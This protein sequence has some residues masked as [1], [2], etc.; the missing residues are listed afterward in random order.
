MAYSKAAPQS[1]LGRVISPAEPVK[2]GDKNVLKFTV[3]VDRLVTYQ[4]SQGKY[5][6]K[7]LYIECYY[8]PYGKNP[9]LDPVIAV[10]TRISTKDAKN[11]TLAGATY[12]YVD[13]WVS[14]REEYFETKNGKLIKKLNHCDVQ[15]TD[16]NLIQAF[17]S[18]K[19]AV[20]GQQGQAQAQ[21]QAA[22]Q[23]APVAPQQAPVA[24]QQVAP[25]A[26]AFNQAT[27]QTTAPAALPKGTIQVIGG[28]PHQLIGDDATSKESWV[29]GTIVDGMFVS[30][31]SQQSLVANST[32]NNAPV[33]PQAA[34]PVAP[35]APQAPAAPV[36]PQAPAA[37]PASVS[38]AVKSALTE[39]V[40][41][42][43][44]QAPPAVP[45]FPQS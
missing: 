31:S 24:P 21:P 33:A 37:V 2:I 6:K 26:P 9:G 8:T 23:Q 12:N 16:N 41:S 34:A 45:T 22:P 36:A 20:T 44:V 19:E 35:V 40:D 13:V 30:A 32:V 14:G 5:Q 25:Q 27:P 28:I 7:S 10:L 17:F 3:A 1:Y 42:N 18:F 38:S 43:F 4:D 11:N 15:I 39:G 29:P